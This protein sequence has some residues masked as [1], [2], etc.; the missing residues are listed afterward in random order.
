MSAVLTR[1]G[2]L[3]GLADRYAPREVAPPPGPVAL[4]RQA[5]ME[6]DDWQ[7]GILLGGSKRLLLCCS[8][9]V[10]KSTVTAALALHT[11]LSEPRSLTLLLAP[12]LRQSQELFRKVGDLM[13]FLDV[14][15]HLA[16]DN[17][18]SLALANRSRIVCLPGKED[19]IR[20]FSG[21]RRLIVDEAS[22]VPDSAYFAVR[23]MLAVSGGSLWALSSPRG[24]RGWYYEAWEHGG[25][26]WERVELWGKDCRRISPEFLAEEKRTLPDRWYRQEYECAFLDTDDQVFAS[27]FI[28]AAVNPD[29]EPLSLW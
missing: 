24:R 29:L 25:P 26:V 10:G 21:V 27:E 16:E 14:K 12:A 8:R 22:R 9:Q 5:G 23:P 11:A 4:M 15:P 2:R 13:A 20:S 28:E 18:L 19:T 17:A 3:E 7:E 6:P 1:L